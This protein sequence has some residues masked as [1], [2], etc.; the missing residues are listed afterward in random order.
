VAR[1]AALCGC[2]LLAALAGCAS[3]PQAPPE[4]DAQAKRF[5]THPGY[6]T[7]YVFRN[8][9]PAGP[10]AQDNT[11]Y[12]NGRIIGATL[13]GTFFRIELRPG[14]HLLHGD[15]PD[16]GSLK[17]GAAADEITFVAMNVL[18]GHSYF[19]R[20]A[21]DAARREI[22]RCCVLMEN[23]APGQRPLLR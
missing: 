15:G 21:P 6:A 1:V 22:L 8:D 20:V 13:P 19:R 23:W 5:L 17:L 4:R 7:L 10:E 9:F 2:L 3:V 18:N 11:L 12:V 16:T 14:A